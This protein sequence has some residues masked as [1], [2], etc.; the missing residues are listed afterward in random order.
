M[1]SVD[2][3]RSAFRK[4]SRFQ[5]DEAIKNAR[6]A[7]AKEAYDWMHARFAT[8]FEPYFEGKQWAIPAGGTAFT[9][10]PM[11]W[12]PRWQLLAGV[13]FRNEIV[14]R[15]AGIQILSVDPSGNLVELFQ[16]ARI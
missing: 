16:S 13:R 12:L 8:A 9:L 2:I 5:P 1:I 6:D 15:P 10:S 3:Q 4:A 14:I 7:G 11:T